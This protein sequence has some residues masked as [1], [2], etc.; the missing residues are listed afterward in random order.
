MLKS[1]LIGSSL[2]IA[3]P[4]LAQDAT[5]EGDATA[6]TGDGTVSAD[7]N[8]NANVNAD[9]NASV[10]AAG[11][12]MMGWWP[13]SAIDRPYMRGK[14]KITAGLD[15]GIAKASVTVA[16]MTASATLD[17]LNLSAASGVSEQINVGL[18]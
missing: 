10:T 5:V 4:A 13:T 17:A 1:V 18:G 15:Y 3:A 12:A 8:A 16:G 2:L 11:S 6:T 9:P 14:G 7:A